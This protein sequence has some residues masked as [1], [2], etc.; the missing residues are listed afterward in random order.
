MQTLTVGQRLPLSNLS[1][2][3]ANLISLKFTREASIDMDISCFALDSSGKLISDDYM[4][5]YNQVLSPCGAIKL[6]AYD[7]DTSAGKRLQASFDV[8]LSN[9]P[10]NVETLYFVL[11]AET[12]LN[13]VQSMD[14]GIW[15]NDQKAN[16]G[17]ASS[18]FG[19]TQASML[20]MLYLKG[21]V[22][23]VTSVAQG[24]NGGLAAIV[25]HFGGDVE[26]GGSDAVVAPKKISIEKVML[27]K[28][29]KLVNLAKKATISL[30]KKQ[31][32]N[33]TAKVALVL[34]ASGSM[35]HQYKKGDVQEVVNRLL[36]LAVG[37]DDDQSLDC[38]AFGERC[39]HLGEIDLNNY[40]D[41]IDKAEGGWRKWK[42]GSRVNNEAAAIAAVNEFYK[43]DG[44]D[45]PVYVLFISDG[46][47]HDSRGIKARITEAAKLP[48]FW[49]FVGLGGRDYGVL[50]KLDDMSGRV[51]D[52]CDFFEVDKLSD[53]SEEQLYDS[54]L[55]EFP[56]W[57]KEAKAKHILN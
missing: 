6:A 46:G 2:N 27:E 48:V 36:P 26:D 51:V 1:I 37:F 7:A 16:A 10:S 33:L 20:M 18:D 55:E 24:F 30:E 21:G 32:Q 56:S 3:E 42:L 9:L 25:K 13:Q 38:W 17:F 8:N 40:E 23:R 19:Q 47:V 57:L 22:W 50:K 53:M 35:N 4:V 49:Q 39:Q 15:Q 52:N 28:A 34:D 11:S 5:F 54:M 29:P 45:V 12:P 14:V 43:D 44:K 41:F 31:L